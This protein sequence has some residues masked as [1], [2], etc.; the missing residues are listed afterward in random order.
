MW[1]PTAE[2][3][4]PVSYTELPDILLSEFPS[5]EFAFKASNT[6]EFERLNV[7]PTIESFEFPVAEIPVIDAP[8]ETIRL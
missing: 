5:I 7:F 8:E 1:K 6:G 2:E 4:V 3:D